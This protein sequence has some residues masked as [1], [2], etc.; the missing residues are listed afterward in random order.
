MELTSNK[1]YEYIKTNLDV[2]TKWLE[3][4]SEFN[5]KKEHEEYIE[6]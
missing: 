4:N 2:I 5:I 1:T 6:K 3:F